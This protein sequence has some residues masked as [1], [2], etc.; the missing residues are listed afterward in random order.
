[1]TK[2][3]SCEPCARETLTVSNG[4]IFASGAD[5]SGRIGR[6]RLVRVSIN[7]AYADGQHNGVP[8][9]G[10]GMEH[11]REY[12]AAAAAGKHRGSRP[13]QSAPALAFARRLVFALATLLFASMWSAASHAQ[14]GPFAG[15][16]GYWSG[17]GT[18]ALD[19]G[20]TERLR[21]RASYAIGAGG[22][23]LNLT[24]T[25]A[26]DSYKFN[27]TSNITAQGSAISG[28]WNESSRN[29]NGNLE[30][31]SGGG[32]FEVVAIAP[33][34]A[35]RLSLTTRGNKQSVTIKGEKEDQFRGATISLSRT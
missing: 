7:G 19:D 25:C 10:S 34:F 20:S 35:A 32:N 31:H 21:C 5:V 24:L 23:G 28:T 30:G 13:G 16:A 26:S 9:G 8:D 6:E 22:T 2:A 14:S 18:V 4:E 1:M 11:L 29:I 3:G 12:R 33:G 15:M 27:L 17:G